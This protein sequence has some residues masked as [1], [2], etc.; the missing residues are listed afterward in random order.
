MIK[1]PGRTPRGWWHTEHPQ[2][3]SHLSNC[4][5]H[6][7]FKLPQASQHII[8]SLRHWDNKKGNL[9]PDRTSRWAPHD[10]RSPAVLHFLS[11]QKAQFPTLYLTRP[12][13]PC[14]DT[15]NFTPKKL[16][17]AG[18]QTNGPS[19]LDNGNKG[20]QAV[21]KEWRTKHSLQHQINKTQAMEPTWYFYLQMLHAGWL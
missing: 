16:A 10:H 6:W 9:V 1:D 12:D 17:N 8:C 18:A 21:G 14:S 3:D 13:H 4:S 20:E 5:H 19:N 7:L 15:T 11:F 2:S